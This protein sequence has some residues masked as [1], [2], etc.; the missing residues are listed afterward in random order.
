MKTA[1]SKLR[2]DTIG[3]EGASEG[4]N[5]MGHGKVW[6]VGAGPGDPGLL[7]LRGREVLSQAEVVVYDALISTRL[8][9]YAPASAERIYVGKQSS[10]H[11]LPQADINRLLV[12][13]GLAGKRV[14][15]LKGGDPMVFGRGGEEALALAEA[16][17]PFEVVPGVTAAIAGAAYAGIPVTHRGLSTGV[18]FVTGHE[19]ED[20]PESDLD[21]DSLAR[22]KGTLVFYMGVANLATIAQNLIAH[23]TDAATPAAVIQWGSTPRQ[24]VVT[25]TL[26]TLPSLAAD[27]GLAPPALIL[28]G[29]VVQL[30]EQ[31][32]WFEQRPLFGRRV[33]VTRSRA[34][35]SD[36]VTRLEELGAETIEA[37]TIR[38]EPPQD[39]EPLRAA[40]RSLEDFDWIIL[41]STNGVDALF[42]TMAAEGLD[43]RALAGLRLAAI[44]PATA[45]RLADFGI[46]AD[47]VPEKFTGAAVAEA[48]AQ[49]GKLNGARVLLP[50]ADI[51]PQE[52]TESLGEHGAVITE[53]TAYRT[54]A[55]FANRDAV[56]ERLDRHEVDWITFTSSSTVRNFLAAMEPNRVRASGAALASIGPTTSATLREAGLAPTVE[57]AEYTIPG[58]V[59]A[60]IKRTTIHG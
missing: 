22:W 37:P 43:A 15:R 19:A 11:T 13:K 8:L 10:R 5:R 16:G 27:A 42:A 33:I 26:S 21:W 28:I 51:A 48:L 17:V 44:G 4:D 20:K 7:T 59:E 46:R 45:A 38:I 29:Q 56:A 36:L 34:Q 57:A 30:R 53:V 40:V 47:L 14:V 1:T 54:V 58:L 31:L 55:D 39:P 52:L 24:R 35:A 2:R 32:S 60:I 25:G 12:E 9:D 49:T 6:L 18:A 50:R 41:T 23:G 3:L